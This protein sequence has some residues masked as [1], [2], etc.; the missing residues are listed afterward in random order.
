MLLLFRSY[1][2]APT[3]F[4]RVFRLLAVLA[5]FA[6]TPGLRAQEYEVDGI[7]ELRLSLTRLCLSLV[8]QNMAAKKAGVFGN[9][10]GA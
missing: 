10:W 7:V 4:C 5:V 9:L 1:R 3:G 2:S 8:E 6:M